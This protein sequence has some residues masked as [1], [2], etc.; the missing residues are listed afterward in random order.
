[1]SAC[2]HKSGRAALQVQGCTSSEPH[3]LLC[4]CCCQ[5]TASQY[6][7][8]VWCT[9]HRSVCREA[10]QHL[11]QACLL[12]RPSQAGSARQRTLLGDM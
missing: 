12:L 9:V 8:C 6:V 2:G 5:R 11:M 3:A 10:M 1:M 4:L 7:C